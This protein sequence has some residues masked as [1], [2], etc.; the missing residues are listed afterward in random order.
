MLQAGVRADMNCASR[1]IGY[2]QALL[3]LQS[4]YKNPGQIAEAG[5]VS[6][7][8]MH[9]CCSLCDH[10]IRQTTFGMGVH[11]TQGGLGAAE[12]NTCRHA[13]SIQ[14]A[15]QKAAHVVSWGCTLQLAGC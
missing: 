2:R 14:A 7:P 15:V 1:G 9:L 3:Y 13:S 4:C 11:V 5:L 8:W 10:D 6:T 12:A